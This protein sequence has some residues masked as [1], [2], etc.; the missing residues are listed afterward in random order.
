MKTILIATILLCLSGV[1]T[2]TQTPP[3][4]GDGILVEACGAK[5]TIPADVK[6]IKI[7][8]FDSCVRGYRSN[9]IYLLLDIL[10][11][12]T[13][14]AS[15]RQEFSREPDLKFSEIKLDGKRAEIISYKESETS[16]TKKGYKYTSV[17]FIPDGHLEL[18]AYLKNPDDLDSIIKIFKSVQFKLE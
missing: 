7:R 9:N 17:L 14:D 11:F 4:L 13:P 12:R 1:T 10:G 16:K 15:W 18:W 2:Y 3:I 5:F 6:E 8:P